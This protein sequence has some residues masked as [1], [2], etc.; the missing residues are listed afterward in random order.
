MPP[1][2][3]LGKRI[4]TFTSSTPGY[5]SLSSK[6]KQ[7]LRVLFVAMSEKSSSIDS[8]K[9][10]FTYFSEFKVNSGHLIR[11]FILTQC[12]LHDRSEACN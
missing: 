3:S 1:I 4:V 5:T 8:K 12:L 7:Y 9:W 11:R 2:S 6:A 10:T